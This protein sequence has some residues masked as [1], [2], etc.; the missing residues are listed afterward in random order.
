MAAGK[1]LLFFLTIVLA[2]WL[3]VRLLESRMVFFPTQRWDFQA[4]RFAPAEELLFPSGDGLSL[5]AVWLP[6]ESPR[7][8]ILYC[9]GNAGNLSHRLPTAS[10]WRRELGFSVLLFD[11]RGYGRSQGRPSEEGIVQDTVAA[12]DQ[13]VRLGGQ[14]VVI[15][16]RSL[17]TV[18]AT[19]AAGQRPAAGLIL[20]SPLTSAKDMASRVLPLPGIGYL[21]S[22]ELNNLESIRRVTCPVMVIHGEWDET[23]PLQQGRRVFEQAPHPKEFLLLEGGRHND[24][25]SNPRILGRFREFLES[26]ADSS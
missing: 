9:H 18:P 22:F 3:L 11:Y 13:A 4:D 23:I 8:V 14:P 17:G 21:S 25:R 2:L 12:F 26:V 19:R 7:G 6:A 16:G 1:T 20:D 15:Y 10:L 5:S 24:E